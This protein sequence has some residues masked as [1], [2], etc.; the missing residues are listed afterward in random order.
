MTLIE[1]ECLGG[2]FRVLVGEI[3][4]LQLTSDDGLRQYSLENIEREKVWAFDL[5][6]W[7]TILNFSALFKKK[8]KEIC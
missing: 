3:E 6:A 2:V 4:I 1:E 7:L 5:F 8:K